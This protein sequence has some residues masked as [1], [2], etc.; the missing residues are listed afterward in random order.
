Y[1]AAHGSDGYHETVT[2]AF[3]LLVRS[4]LAART[5]GE[6]FAAFRGRNG[7][8]FEGR[9]GLLGR[10]YDPGTL[11]SAEARRRFVP[12]DREPLQGGGGGRGG[13]GPPGPGAAEGGRRRWGPARGR[14]PQP[15]RRLDRESPPG[16]PLP[17][18]RSP[19]GSPGRAAGGARGGR[20]AVRA[21]R[22]GPDLRGL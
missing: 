14:S 5:P 15:P 20:L 4:R 21:R 2:V 17:R 6:D 19:V 10:H 9:A 3:A 22:A 8:L 13:F 16:E 12:P 1:N 18:P 11:A 7:D